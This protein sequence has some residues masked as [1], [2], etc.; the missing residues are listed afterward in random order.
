MKC[1]QS[2]EI[3]YF[4]TLG[5]LAEFWVPAMKERYLPH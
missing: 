4:Q 1:E 5:L 3:D 2:T